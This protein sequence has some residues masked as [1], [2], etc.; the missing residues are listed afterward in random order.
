MYIVCKKYTN[1]RVP[2]H[3]TY[4]STSDKLFNRLRTAR[5][6]FSLNIVRKKRTKNEERIEEFSVDSS[7][8]ARIFGS[9]YDR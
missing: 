7:V 8:H 9:L 1:T 5:R 3:Y 6:K 4:V 2:T